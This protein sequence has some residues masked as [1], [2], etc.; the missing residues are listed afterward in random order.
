MQMTYKNKNKQLEDEI[1]AL[2]EALKKKD[3]ESANIADIS[4]KSLKIAYEILENLPLGLVGIGLDGI[5]TIVNHEAKRI[6]N[7]GQEGMVGENARE[8]LPKSIYSIC[9][10][11]LDERAHETVA[12]DG[13]GE[14]KV[15]VYPLGISSDARGI[16]LLL[17]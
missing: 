14:V 1:V 8:V 10:Q 17:V 16:L 11:G 13:G 6:L 5:V 3:E 9:D 12:I 2:R 15:S 4:T 7:K